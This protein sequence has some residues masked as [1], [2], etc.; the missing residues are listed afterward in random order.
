MI[1]I[2]KTLADDNKKPGKGFDLML[3]EMLIV[4][5]TAIYSPN[6]LSDESGASERVIELYCEGMDWASYRVKFISVS[7]DRVNK[8]ISILDPLRDVPRVLK[9]TETPRM[10]KARGSYSEGYINFEKERATLDASHAQYCEN[11]ERCNLYISYTTDFTL[12]R[13]TGAFEYLVVEEVREEQS[14]NLIAT[15]NSW[16]IFQSAKCRPTKQQ[17]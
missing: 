11:I 10:Y 5:A 1:K 8:S 14:D 2:W 7:I 13:Q 3:K 15:P 9:L 4:V 12:N 16:G 6:L 17:Y